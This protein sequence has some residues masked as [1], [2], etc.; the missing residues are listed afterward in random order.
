MAKI[1]VRR[2]GKTWSVFEGEVL[3]EGGF[4]DREAA[5]EVAEAAMLATRVARSGLQA[6]AD[7]PALAAALRDQPFE[8]PPSEQW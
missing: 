8:P 6:T 2:T 4:F 3:L 5:R 7:R 1:T